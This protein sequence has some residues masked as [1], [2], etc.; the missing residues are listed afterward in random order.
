MKE[1]KLFSRK[2]WVTII[3]VIL[4]VLVALGKLSPET[5]DATT[6]TILGVIA[7]I[8]SILGYNFA[9]GSVDKAKEINK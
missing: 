7:S 4:G 3:G 8:A 2:L 5:A 9:Q 6:Q 1:S